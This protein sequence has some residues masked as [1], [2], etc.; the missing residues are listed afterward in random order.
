M[1]GMLL[2]YARRSSATELRFRLQRTT[3]RYH[4]FF[5]GKQDKLF[6][7]TMIDR[8]KF[9]DENI[10]VYE[11]GGRESV[12]EAS[13]NISPTESE[14]C[15]YFIDSDYR[16]GISPKENVFVTEK[17]SFENYIVTE[18]AFLSILKVNFGVTSVAE[19]ES[20][21]QKF[22]L[23]HE[24]ASILLLRISRLKKLFDANGD[25]ISW[26][27]LAMEYLCELEENGRVS[28]AK[29]CQDT[30]DRLFP[31][32]VKVDAYRVLM[33]EQPFSDR[34]KLSRG[35]NMLKLVTMLIDQAYGICIN[36]PEKA[37]VKIS[38]KSPENMIRLLASLSS[39]PS[40]LDG[41]LEKWAPK[42]A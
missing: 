30:F 5:E 17:Y 35:K 7:L 32:G 12:V 3:S 9:K 11:C 41:F 23:F 34:H 8:T 21:R 28:R 27:K 15:L 2:E 24:S 40:D 16:L 36:S 29:G 1:K 26:D 6:Y 20:F 18:E 39:I 13:Q 37:P 31:A 19:R 10:T 4:M 22:H 25:G 14:V 33:V 38:D 42:A